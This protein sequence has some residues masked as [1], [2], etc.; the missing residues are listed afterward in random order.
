[1]RHNLLKLANPRVMLSRSFLIAVYMWLVPLAAVYPPGA[2]TITSKPQ[3][4]TELVHMSVLEPPIPDDFNAIKTLVTPLLAFISGPSQDTPKYLQLA[5][6]GYD[7]MSIS[8]TTS[9]D[10]PRESLIEFT[11]YVVSRGEILELPP[12]PSGEN[13]S[14]TLTFTGPQLSCTEIVKPWNETAQLFVNETDTY[15]DLSIGE[16]GQDTLLPGLLSWPVTQNKILGTLNCTNT[17]GSWGRPNMDDQNVYSI[18]KSAMS[19]SE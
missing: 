3:L 5:G 18:E 1:M 8:Y 19:C 15:Q 14:C 17:N 16:P 2:L 10:R 11:R 9:Y 4:R 13:S 12:P 7:N 6:Y